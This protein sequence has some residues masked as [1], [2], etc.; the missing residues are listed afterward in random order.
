MQEV[1]GNRWSLVALHIPGR[2]GQ[3]CAQRWRHK[4]GL[5]TNSVYRIPFLKA[6][7]RVGTAIVT[8]R[9]I[10]QRLI[11]CHILQVNPNIRKEKWT[12]SEDRQLA[13]LVAEHGNRWADIA[14]QYV[15][16]SCQRL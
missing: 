14:R 12:A 1:H 6:A 9:G 7:T 16:A 2:T 8:L 3:Q 11:M 5:R 4:V 10:L 13:S 15:P